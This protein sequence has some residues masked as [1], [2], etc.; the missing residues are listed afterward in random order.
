MNA[1]FD[2]PPRAHAGG[3]SRTGHYCPGCHAPVDPADPECGGCG[4]RIPSV[5]PLVGYVFDDRYRVVDVIGHGGMAVVYW[6]DDLGVPGEREVALKL[7]RPDLLQDARAIERFR[8]E[9]ARASQI[10]HPNAVLVYEHGE[11][12]DGLLYLAME[13]LIGTP[14]GE[15]IRQGR[16]LAE[17]RAVELMIQIAGAVGEAHRIGLVHRDLK[18]DNVMVEPGVANQPERAVVLDFGIAKEVRATPEPRRRL[19]RL[20]RRAPEPLPDPTSGPLTRDGYVMGTP[21]YMSPE[22]AAGKPIDARSDVFSLGLLLFE[23]LAGELPWEPHDRPGSD[24]NEPGHEPRRLRTLAEVRP[25][26]QVSADL[27]RI[28]QMALALDTGW[29]Y[30]DGAALMQDLEKL[31]RRMR[32]GAADERTTGTLPPRSTGRVTG[33]VSG[34]RSGNVGA[35]RT[36]TIGGS[37][38]G[39]VGS[40]TGGVGPRTGHLGPRRK[41]LRVRD[42]LGTIPW[43]AG[44]AVLLAAIGLTGWIATSESGRAEAARWMQRFGLLSPH[45]VV[46]SEP[47]AAT[48]E[49]GSR[50]GGAVNAAARPPRAPSTRT[51]A[52]LLGDGERALDEHRWDDARASFEEVMDRDRPSPRALIGLARAQIGLGHS[53]DSQN[54]FARAVDLLA[55]S[56][57]KGAAAKLT[58]IRALAQHS[59]RLDGLPESA[60]KLIALGDVD[61]AAAAYTEYLDARPWDGA[62]EL[63]LGALLARANRLTEAIPHLESAV[64]LL[65]DE[66]TAHLELGRAYVRVK[67]HAEARAELERALTIDPDL[68]EARRQ[69]DIA[70]SH[71]P[72][73]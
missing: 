49:G 62:V 54:S 61:G 52:Q 30:A 53:D 68:A 5:D 32:E 29:R 10:H 67:Q 70:R 44:A 20:F 4:Q 14:L 28:L 57:E 51:P 55:S 8:R 37:R 40:R 35:G 36:G 69:L 27:A 15:L 34:A 66:A 23:M 60:R 47:R 58:E 39:S 56:K 13:R 48:G 46:D 7:L 12:S 64:R 59:L 17:A 50:A 1:P 63:K 3:V 21:D 65:P 11:F 19:G 33:G 45:A 26:V 18:P 31:R 42:V 71:A 2:E 16:G 41:R 6:A 73:S 9:S 24:G 22:Q 25:D 72:P 43:L 38:T